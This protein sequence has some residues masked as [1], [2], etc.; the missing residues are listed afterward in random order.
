MTHP[1]DD[2]PDGLDDLAAEP[3]DDPDDDTDALDER[4]A[5]DDT[6]TV[7]SGICADDAPRPYAGLLL[8][9]RFPGVLL[10]DKPRG[11]AWLLDNTGGRWKVR[12]PNGA[13]LDTA[14]R[15]QAAESAD[16]EVRAYDPQFTGD[17]APGT[18]EAH[19]TDGEAVR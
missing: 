13:P 10:A 7:Y 17:T 3:D 6:A 16:W 1:D 19:G 9:A 18:V 2:D 11:L 14:R 12:D 15:W 8:T 5:D 4:A